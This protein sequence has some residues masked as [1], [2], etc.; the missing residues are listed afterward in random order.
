MKFLNF[1]GNNNENNSKVNGII[2][3]IKNLKKAKIISIIAIGFAFILFIAV[4][5][6]VIL[7]IF[8]SLAS[9]N[10]VERAGAERFKGETDYEQKVIERDEFLNFTQYFDT[11]DEK[12]KEN[13]DKYFD[14]LYDAY[15]FYKADEQDKKN[16]WQKVSSFFRKFLN[17]E[18]R[19][20][21]APLYPDNDKTKMYG[22][23]ID[24]TLITATLYNSRYQSEMTRNDEFE[25]EFS[26]FVNPGEGAGGAGKQGYDLHTGSYRDFIENNFLYDSKQS[27]D[28]K[29]HL[30]QT[31]KAI[32]GIEVL[33]KYQIKRIE[34]YL[35]IHP[36]YVG[37][38]TDTTRHIEI[39]IVDVGMEGQCISRVGNYGMVLGPTEYYNRVIQ[40]EGYYWNCDPNKDSICKQCME[41]YDL[42]SYD[43]D[44]YCFDNELTDP[45]DAQGIYGCKETNAIKY[46]KPLSGPGD[47]GL[48]D[49]S[50]ELDCEAYNEYLLGNLPTD[51]D[52][53]MFCGKDEETGKDNCYC[54]RFI[55]SY[56]HQYVNREDVDQKRRDISQI[57][58]ETYS[59]YSY[60]E[61]STMIYNVCSDKGVDIVSYRDLSCE[62]KR[63]Y[64]YLGDIP[65][66]PE[67]Y[68]P[69]IDTE[70]VDEPVK[71]EVCGTQQELMNRIAQTALDLYNNHA[72]EFTYTTNNTTRANTYNGI[73]T[74][75]RFGTDCNGFVGYTIN[76]ALGYGS[77]VASSS[78]KSTFTFFGHGSGLGDSWSSRT[79]KFTKVASGL[80]LQAALES[81]P[82][83][84][85]ISNYDSDGHH[86]QVYVGNGQI[87][88]MA[89]KDG[90]TLRTMNGTGKR[91]IRH[92][93]G[94]FEI[95]VPNAN[96]C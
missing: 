33:A 73:K 58:F 5:M 67:I 46:S 65:Y 41:T 12:L 48:D 71:V 76:R 72:R 43:D 74:N 38:Y 42:S 22:V 2:K 18:K 9:L 55:E 63:K 51:D 14:S 95:F 91:G 77:D 85:L 75:G 54:D 7:K 61:N 93:D 70:K 79:D 34:T 21:E 25:K 36:E 44:L 94:T 47:I 92:K 62:G 20:K 50:Y 29:Y 15:E 13:N 39:N 8:A 40:T 87:V 64:R 53:E 11:K 69:I 24:T 3:S 88:D 59:L 10:S 81:A 86:I 6:Y 49:L 19:K 84:S 96:N 66:E 26:Y 31:K 68:E 78:D 90:L 57:V 27:L 52:V 17:P 35:T 32:E 89:N 1:M 82:V 45:S 28:S 37:T 4:F 56:Y 30:S 16:F 80:S 60:Y 83:G 23:E